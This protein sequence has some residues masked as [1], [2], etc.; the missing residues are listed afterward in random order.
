MILNRRFLA[1]PWALPKCT[2]GS[3]E[4]GYQPLL[5]EA[6]LA[7]LRPEERASGCRP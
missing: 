1:M 5:P 3:W 7:S 2:S 4:V 6:Y